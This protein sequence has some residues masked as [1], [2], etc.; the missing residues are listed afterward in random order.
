MNPMALKTNI[1]LPLAP[2]HTNN[3]QT[4]Q[5]SPTTSSKLMINEPSPMNQTISADSKDPYGIMKDVVKS[6]MN[7]IKIDHPMSSI[8]EKSKEH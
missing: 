1:K 8:E 2:G 5:Q 7:S 6:N 3:F 4:I